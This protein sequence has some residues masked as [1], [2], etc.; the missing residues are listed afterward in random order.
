MGLDQH[1]FCKDGSLTEDGNEKATEVAYWRKFNALHAWMERNLN[2]GLPTNCDHLTIDGEQMAGLM[3][4]CREIVADPS[5]ALEL[6]P[7]EEG[8]FFG[9]TEVDEWYLKKCQETAD[10]LQAILDAEV[11]WCREH[12][13]QHR[14]Y[15]YWSWW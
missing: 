2:G 10:T 9:G 6:L 5:K 14:T 4:T 8:F 13:G 15:T 7:P 11:L 12:P 1:L 3:V